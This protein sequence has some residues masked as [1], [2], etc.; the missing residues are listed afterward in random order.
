MNIS[1]NTLDFDIKRTT[2]AD[3][4]VLLPTGSIPVF[5]LFGDST[6]GGAESLVTECLTEDRVFDEPY[7]GR[8]MGMVWNTW[9]TTSDGENFDASGRLGLAGAGTAFE[10]A[11]PRGGGVSPLGSTPYEN[12][13]L[14]D[15]LWG[16]L[17]GIF[18]LFRDETTGEIIIPRVVRVSRT[19]AIVGQVATAAEKAFSYN[20]Q[21]YGE[22]PGAPYAAFATPL[23]MLADNIDAAVTALAGTQSFLCGA[24]T[25]AGFADTK[26]EYNTEPGNP[27]N[28]RAEFSGPALQ[29]IRE[30][31]EERYSVDQFPMI[32]TTARKI[33]GGNNANDYN[34]IAASNISLTTWATGYDQTTLVS[35]DALGPNINA[36][37]NDP[38]NPH[39][40]GNATMRLG[41]LWAQTYRNLLANPEVNVTAPQLTS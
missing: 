25:T 5:L 4:A 3:Q 18:G 9:L 2:G 39:L 22:T 12:L 16:F 26:S 27:V 13:T 17:R 36:D 19:G 38:A 41:R 30:F 37:G 33:T 29:E 7:V 23:T 32:A 34:S 20:V 1:L 10:E 21:Y 8:S 35:P 14:V 6:A 11:V 28:A 31:F 15:P 24:V 40:N